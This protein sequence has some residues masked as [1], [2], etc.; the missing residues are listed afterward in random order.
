MRYSRRAA[1]A[2]Q[3]SAEI[4]TPSATSA[5]QP[6]PAAPRINAARAMSYVRDVVGFGPRFVGSPGHKKTEAYISAHL[7][8][9]NV[10]DDDFTAATP[11]GPLAM[12]NII[13]KFPGSKSGVV[14]IATHYDTLYGRKDFV[15][16]NDG[17]SG[18]GLLLELANQLR[19][20]GRSGYSIWLVWLDGEEAIRQWSDTDSTYGSRHLAGK[21]QKDGTLK[22]V[23]AFLLADMIGDADLNIE[24]DRNST[25]WLEDLVYEAATALGYQS[26]F[27]RREEAIDDD[28]I[29]F[30]RA[31]VPV[32]DLI[33]FDYGYANS[34][35]HT[36][37][38]TLDKLSPHSLQIV[39]DVLLESVG[40]LDRR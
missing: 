22:R 29:P 9:A 20:P 12:R 28:H 15:G 35:W 27:F 24:H 16:A 38:D 26:H 3:S 32:A 6:A 39:G 7:K 34:Y 19:G 36:A 1:A 40:L 11:A 17:G 37:Q 8:G 25:P 31:G 14:V 21:W 13:A 4:G 5:A 33:D 18:T 30:A 23:K 10:E 2:H